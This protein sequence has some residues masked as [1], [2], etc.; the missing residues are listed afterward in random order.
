MRSRDLRIALALA[1]L[2]AVFRLPRLHAPAEEYFDEVYHA[3]SARQY[4]AGE[5]PIEWVH[6]PMAKLLIAAGVWAFGYHPW[7]WRLMPALFGVALAPLF[8]LFAR[9]V[10][11]TERAALLASVLLLADGVYLVQSRIAMTNIFAVV[12]QVGAVFLLLRAALLEPLPAGGMLAVGLVLGLALATRW[13]SLF[14]M[15][16]MGLVFLALRR[17]RVFR[18][19]ELGLAAL[20][21]G[22]IPLLVYFGSYLPLKEVK[23]WQTDK[24]GL[25]EVLELQRQVWDYHANLNASH[26]YFSKW[27]SWPW[28]YRP[29]WYYFKQKDE[30]IEGIVAL[31]NPPLWWASL[32]IAVWALAA[33]RKARDPRLLFAGFGYCALF[34]P[35][36][37]APRTLNYSHYLFEALPYAC[38]A[39]GTL[40]D[41]EW[42]GRFG[43]LARGYLALV[44]A[45]FL[46]F[47]PFLMGLPV[48]AWAFGR[49]LFDDVRPWTWF[50]RWV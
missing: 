29:T 38:L 50:P 46:F 1:L 6:P 27:Y 26:P 21:F 37:I 48:P 49:T 19:R 36:G 15:A 39:L 22:V 33:G 18:P 5:M 47:V 8:Y 41:R 32:P 35:W 13:T 14:A 24:H 25:A 43:P 45:L 9:R 42:D 23:S 10:L 30:R 2:A 20:A 11:A 17:L 44:V 28:L 7:A 31:G 34:L 40:L 3:V 4:L 12:F 16:F